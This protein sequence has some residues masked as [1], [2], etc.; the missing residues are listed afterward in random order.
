MAAASARGPQQAFD[1]RQGAFPL[2]RRAA[3]EREPHQQGPDG[4]WAG[5]DLG[6][7]G[8][9]PGRVSGAI[10]RAG[11]RDWWVVAERGGL[12][13]ETQNYV[14]KLMAAAIIGKHPERYGFT[15][16]TYQEPFTYDAVTVEGSVTLDVLAKCAGTDEETL[17]EMNPAL[18]RQATPPDGETVIYV[19][20][21]S[22]EA[23][24]ARFAE[25]PADQRVTYRRHRVARGESLGKIAAHY[26]VSVSDL[27]RFNRIANPNRIYV[28]TELIIPVPG[29]APPPA[30]VASAPPRG[31]TPGQDAARAASGATVHH[32]VARG[33]TLSG[34]AAR[35][36]VSEAELKAWNGLS[37]ANHIEVGQRL[38][39]RGGAPSARIASTYTVARGD[40]LTA[41]AARYGVSVAELQEWNNIRNPSSIRVGQGLKI[42]TPAAVW[43]THT[44]RA[45]DSLGRIARRYGCSVKDLQSWNDLEG[46]VIQP[47][48][49]LRVRKG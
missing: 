20:A 4:A 45:G 34:I 9:G 30:A 16:I 33:D 23:F 6:C 13:P 21:G 47:G 41:I 26:G 2:R 24:A 42:Y 39:L 18:L 37:D 12:H 38:I 31:T 3:P 19:P 22:G 44:V 1:R 32:T 35:Y 28:G 11:S 10:R 36:G 7:R 29:A 8:Q 40:N 5:G 43:T 46:S 14:P 17:R 25:I 49:T 48:Q 27:T 15:D